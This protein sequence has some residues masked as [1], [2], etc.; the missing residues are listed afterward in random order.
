MIKDHA[1]LTEPVLGAVFSLYLLSTRPEYITG[2]DEWCDGCARRPLPA[3]AASRCPRRPSGRRWCQHVR[4]DL[5]I[6]PKKIRPWRA[7]ELGCLLVMAVYS[8]GCAAAAAAQLAPLAFQAATFAGVSV[9]SAVTG[10]DPTED[11]EDTAER[12]DALA[13][14]PAYMAELMHTG[15]G[16][17]LRGLVLGEQGGKPK[18]FLSSTITSLS[19]LQFTPPL[20]AVQGDPKKRNF[21]AYAAAQPQNDQENN[22]LVA[23]LGSF[24]SGPGVLSIDG[25]NYHY[26]WVEKL[27]CFQS[28]Q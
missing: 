9:G 12:C 5:S 27:P 13:T 11:E 19:A 8:S 23:F 10:K 24:E 18:W 20:S 25:R 6:D 4:T 16:E 28:A 14:T 3:T 21:L 1:D 17:A 26:A 2:L 15:D 22:Q 7:A